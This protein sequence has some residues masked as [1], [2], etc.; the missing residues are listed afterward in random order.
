MQFGIIGAG[1]VGRGRA[2]P[3]WSS[4]DILDRERRAGSPRVGRVRPTALHGRDANGGFCARLDAGSARAAGL[5][6]VR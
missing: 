1:Y 4:V 6:V 3:T 2:V 5:Q